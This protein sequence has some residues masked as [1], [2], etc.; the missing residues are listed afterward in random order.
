MTNFEKSRLGEK[1]VA[2]YLRREG[3]QVIPSNVNG[4]DW[5]SEKDGTRSLIEVKTTSNLNGGIP[6]M[7]DTE[8][9]CSNGRW[10][11]VADFLYIVRL[12]DNDRV[13][14][15]NILEKKEV[16]A[17]A[18]SHRTVTRVRTTKLDSA[19]KRGAVGTTIDVTP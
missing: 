15:L 7:H 2:E 18:D 5:I 9:T 16:D 1:Y 19:I 10:L 13:V 11:L 12:D 4:G 8:F 3:C 17:F 6:D 14:Q